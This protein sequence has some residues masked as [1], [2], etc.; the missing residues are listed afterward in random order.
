MIQLTCIGLI[1]LLSAIFTNF[2]ADYNEDQRIK[3]GIIVDDDHQYVNIL[4][5]NF[6]NNEQFTALFDIVIDQKSAV[7]TAFERG[8]LDAY[9]VI[10]QFFTANML[11][12]RANHIT[13]Y[14]HLGFPTKTKVL[15][16]LFAA[17][18]RYVQTSNSATLAFYDLLSAAN[19]DQATIV[20]AN[21]YFSLEII[22]VALGR[23]KLFDIA[24]HDA[25]SGLSASDYFAVA[26]SF[27]IIGLAMIPLV[28]L[29]YLDMK[30]QVT[31]RL[32]T[33]GL[34]NA[35]YL[36]NLHL[37]QGI[38]ALLQSAVIAVAWS[39]YSGANPLLI[40]LAFGG[41]T[42]FWS[43]TW[44]SVALLLNNRQLYFISSTIIAFSLA[45]LGGSITPFTIMPLH[46]K[47]LAN[48][49]PLLSFSKLALGIDQTG[50]WLAGWSL[51]CVALYCYQI[52]VV[53][54]RNFGDLR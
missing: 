20:E 47:L 7:V 22:S 33:T 30:N 8:E 44:L 19:L 27:A 16:S 46:L 54:R 23:N 21:K 34:S 24:A 11:S 29:S 39:L 4:L 18:S 52:K 9:A 43:I 25:L 13:I 51:L 38:S 26:L 35:F 36:L 12:Y 28:D 17:Y 31:A 6:T 32:L 5:S 14:S 50:W 49:S 42:L 3:L 48:F 15:K 41:M 2:G 45:L 37:V 10:P 53:S 40:V 1:V